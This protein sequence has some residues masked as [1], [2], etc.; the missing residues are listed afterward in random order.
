M[1]N[2]EFTLKY[3]K[4]TVT[5]QIPEEQ[6]LYEIKGRDRPAIKDLE[7]AYR[8]ALD[9]PIDAPPLRELVRPGERVAILVSDI[10]RGWQKNNLTLPIL[11]DVLNEAGVSDPDVTVVIAVG[12]HRANTKEEFVEICSDEVCHRVRVL[13]HNSEDEKSMVYFGKTSRGTEVSLNKI[14]KEVDRVILTGGSIYHYMVGYGGGRKSIMPGISSA[15]TISQCHSWALA[16]VV[17]QGVNPNS[18]STHTRGNEA[19]EDMVEVA[20]FVNADFLVNVVVNLE[21]EIAGIFAGNWMTAWEAANRLV[22]EMCAIEIEEEADIVIASGEG[23]PRDMNLYQ[24][25]KILNNAAHAMKKGGV[26]VVLAE[27]SDMPEP[28]EYFQWFDHPDIVTMEKE[29]RKN[30]TIAGWTALKA[31]TCH[32]KGYYILLTMAENDELARKARCHPVTKIEDALE[33][34]YKKCGK[35]KPTITVMPQASNTFPVLMAK[36]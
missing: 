33:I 36:T 15:K 18:E 27:C 21:G 6:L 28:P 20:A 8:Q 5:F 2:R 26:A 16:P 3:G 34:A 11:I 7:A 19:H 1:A 32:E 4:G 25:A 13:N 35:P 24:G 9:H 10:T 31:L 12:A 22:D 29:L 17:G 23:Y 30:V 14:V